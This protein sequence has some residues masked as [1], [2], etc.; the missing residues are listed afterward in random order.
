[1]KISGERMRQPNAKNAFDQHYIR[2]TMVEVR[3]LRPSQQMMLDVW[4]E[5]ITNG[6]TGS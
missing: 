6:S 5:R 1:M 2:P 4:A 3:V